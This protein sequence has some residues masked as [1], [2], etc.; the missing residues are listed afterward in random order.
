MENT[1][2]FCQSEIFCFSLI[3]LINFYNIS[4]FTVSNTITF[5]LVV[6]LMSRS[7][8]LKC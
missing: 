3:F 7:L 6:L 5:I 1:E 4:L 8:L 2:N